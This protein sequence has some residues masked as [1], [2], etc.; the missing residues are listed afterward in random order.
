[1]KTCTVCK[2]EKDDNCYYTYKSG[3]QI[4]GLFA[5]CKDCDKNKG[6][7][8]LEIIKADPDKMKT[9]RAY[10]KAYHKARSKNISY[11]IHKYKDDAEDRGFVWELTNEEAALFW[12][13]PCTYCGNTING[14]GIDRVDSSIGYKLSNCVPCCTMCNWMKKDYSKDI[15][16]E[17]IE[18]IAKHQGF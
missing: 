17:H 13:V 7:A 15:W 12:H 10:Q 1:M 2:E 5:H 3:K 16:L 9:H 18:R 14:L 4:G 6:K 8:R 11:R